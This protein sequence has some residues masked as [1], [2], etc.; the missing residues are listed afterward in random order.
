MHTRLTI[1]RI[2]EWGREGSILRVRLTG[3]GSSH[4]P[5]APYVLVLELDSFVHNNK[6]NNGVHIDGCA[7]GACCWTCRVWGEVWFKCS[8]FF[9][10]RQLN[11]RYLCLL[12]LC[13][14]S[15]G[16]FFCC[17]KRSMYWYT[18]TL[19]W[20]PGWSCGIIT[21][22]CFLL[23]LVHKDLEPCNDDW[24]KTLSY[25]NLIFVVYFW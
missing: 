22:L 15:W 24:L 9:K 20:W 19:W 11:Q 17:D 4:T 7:A 8:P 6:P 14:F 1:F 23:L 21:G 25:I 16:L 2:K 13:F 5:H 12:H 18:P 10:A 3:P